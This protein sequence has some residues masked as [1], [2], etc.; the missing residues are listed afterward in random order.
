MIYLALLVGIGGAFV[1]VVDARR[2]EPPWLDRTLIALIVAGLLA[3]PL[4]VGLQG[5]DALDLRLPAL[6]QKLVW[7]TGLETSYGLTAIAAHGRAVRGVVRV[8]GAWRDGR[9]R[10]RACRSPH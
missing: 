1:R 8:R 5:L 10:A 7:E 4:S 2:T 9:R 6:A 3:T